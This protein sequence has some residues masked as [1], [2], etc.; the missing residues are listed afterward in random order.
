MTSWLTYANRGATRN[1]PL[2]PGLIAKL[3]FL[4]EMGLGAEVFS[5]GQETLEEVRAGR[6]SRTGS[7]RHDHGN[8]ADLFITRGGQ[9]LSWENP[10]HLPIFQ[11]VVRRAKAAG[12]TGI[13]A[14][15][16]Y[17]QPGSIHMGLGTPSV[18]GAG[19]KGRNA[20]AWLTQAYNNAPGVTLTSSPLAQD[21]APPITGG[22]VIEDR[23]IAGISDAVPVAAA[24]PAPEVPIIDTFQN[25][26]FKAGMKALAGNKDAMGGLSNLMQAMG[27][28]GKSEQEKAHEVPIQSILPSM[29]SAD[30]SRMANAQQM[31]AQLLAAKR[32][33]ATPGL[34][35]NGMV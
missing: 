21:R 8:A 3:R 12:I 26:G 2:D 11:D 16:G 22:R 28:G 6:G 13:G 33:K 20:P 23:P 32:K 25:E 15:P 10:E 19:G 31:M 34:S 29:E 9:R 14:G 4:E 17:M 30:V 27:G 18:W 5:G 24:V 7:T 1:D 35:L